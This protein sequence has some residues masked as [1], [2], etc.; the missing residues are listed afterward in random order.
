[1]V[2]EALSP[3]K[4]LE[5]SERVRLLE[6][7]EERRYQPGDAIIASGDL[8]DD[9]FIL[10]SG[11]AEI[12]R[13]DRE[14]VISS[15]S[16]LA[17]FGERASLFH[18]PRRVRVR[19]FD[20]VVCYAA[21]G[22][23][24]LSLLESLPFAQALARNLRRK[25]GLFDALESFCAFLNRDA[26]KGVI[27]LEGLL[28]E[29]RALRPALHP[30][31]EEPAIDIGAWSY[32]LRRLPENITRTFVLL[33]SKS[34]PSVFEKA[35][36]TAR[37]ISTEA[38][39]RTAWALAPGKDL[40]VLRDGH[41]DLID[42]I[43][44]LCLHA[45]EARKLRR[46][47]R[48]SAL[49]DQIS[50]TLAAGDPA[51][52]ERL[53]ARLPLSPEEAAGLKSLWGERALE[54]VREI[55]LHHEDYLICL[56]K[57]LNNYSADGPERWTETLRQGV[58]DLMGG[59]DG[60]EVDVISSNTHSVVNCF[61][62]RVHSERARIL[63]WAEEKAPELAAAPFRNPCDRLYAAARGFFQA[64]P[65]EARLRDEAERAHGLVTLS[66]QGLTGIQV[67]LIDPARL[68]PKHR[69]PALRG[70]PGGRRLIVN[71]DYAFGR[72]AE[73]IM[74]YL[75]LLFGRAIRSVNVLGKAG[76]L[77][78]RRGDI[79]AASHL[80]MQ[81]DDQVL[82]GGN[83]DID[84]EALGERSGVAVHHGVML[85]VAGTLLQ[86]A[87][88]LRYYRE[89]WRCIGLEMEGSFYAKQI[90]RSRQLGA[91][92]SDVATRFLYYI[93]D[94]PLEEASNLSSRLRPWEGIPPLYATTRAVLARLLGSPQAGGGGCLDA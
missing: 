89:L 22:S 9:F 47:L 11:Q 34:I 5:H 68:H 43:G 94:L 92:R 85:T 79:L 67:D 62:P 74:G 58:I 90:E 7:L 12:V 75:I 81:S 14:S 27:D 86:N 26:S 35:E 49:V 25:Q 60:L 66:S 33:L 1:M 44:N 55:I 41:T 42:F 31:V 16:A 24:F 28:S 10:A 46:R 84:L 52:G 87:V 59:L 83:A 36:G 69:D 64:F 19:A 48:S 3:F 78:G 91:L 72:Q 54:R 88:L 61:S 53:L 57:A 73:D 93:S 15:L 77:I 40:I 17:Y 65:E 37:P 18:E 30:G 51:R 6:E 50:A 45:T 82:P 80:V 39:R 8:S 76:G 2:L 56:D 23:V 13:A 71:I 29:Y 32:A 38:R 70:F 21:S 4:Y 20:E 63:R